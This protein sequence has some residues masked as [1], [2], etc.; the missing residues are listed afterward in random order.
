M[1]VTDGISGVSRTERNDT[2]YKVAAQA[3][4]AIMNI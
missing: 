1:N 2:I 3:P 4:G